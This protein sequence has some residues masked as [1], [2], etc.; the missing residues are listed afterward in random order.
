MSEIE[1]LEKEL[2]LAT[3]R[4]HTEQV[5][6]RTVALKIKEAK[7]KAGI[8]K[9]DDATAKICDELRDKADCFKSTIC[10]KLLNA[11]ADALEHKGGTELLDLDDEL[12][13]QQ[14]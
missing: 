5:V 7:I 3:M 14:K 8:I 13:R 10:K 12:Y 11:L 1:R 9:V 2:E 6:Y 4:L